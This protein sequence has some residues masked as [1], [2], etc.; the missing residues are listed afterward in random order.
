MPSV[1]LVNARD[2]PDTPAASGR[3]LRYPSPFFDLSQANLPDDI[4]ELFQWCLFYYVATPLIPAVVNKLS[5]Y[6][7]TDV[8]VQAKEEGEED[9]WRNFLISKL[10]IQF[11]LYEMNIDWCLYGNAIVGLYLPFKRFLGCKKCG[12]RQPMNGLDWRVKFKKKQGIEFKMKC[13][14]CKKIKP[15]EVYDVE[16]KDSSKVNIVRYNPNNIHIIYDIS[17]GK[18]KYLWRIPDKYKHVILSGNHPDIIEDCPYEVL[19]AINEEKDMILNDDNLFHMKRPNPSGAY[20]GFGLPLV[21]HALKWTYYFHILQSAQEAIAHDK[22]VPLDFIFPAPSGAGS[23]PPALSVG[24]DRFKREIEE[25][26][27]VQKKD[28]N[29]K[30]IVPFPIGTSRM[31]GDARAMML[32]PEI[33]WVS[34]QIISSMGVPVEFVYGGL[35]WTG[36]SITLRMLENS[37]TGMRDQAD[38][39]ISFVVGRVSKFMDWTKPEAYLTELKMADDIARQQLAMGLEASGKISTSS[40]LDELD[41]DFMAEEE[42]KAKEFPI[43]AKAMIREA[44]LNA[45]AQGEAGVLQNNYMMRTQ[46]QQQAQAATMG[47]DPAT[48]A[49][50]DQSGQP[51]DPNTGMPLDP[52]TGLPF[53]PNTG[54][55]YNPETGEVMT[56]EEAEEYVYSQQQGVA[57][58]QQA[59]GEAPAEGNVEGPGSAVDNAILSQEEQRDQAQE[60]AAQQAGSYQNAPIDLKKLITHWAQQL[61]GADQFTQRQYLDMIAED[62]PEVAELIEQEIQMIYAKNMQQGGASS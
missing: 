56:P 53:D 7:I 60:A 51:V 62:T 26:I 2:V 42:K 27:K 4:K 54:E 19:K 35:T 58:E 43:K 45:R 8:I 39:F 29:K 37:L 15:A 20:E 11:K 24:L 21:I 6:P 1:E 55:Y 16:I 10:N 52:N 44:M 46:I 61:A 31:G 47:M 5:Q 50:V 9:K 38:R 3:I 12:T 18:T 59:A 34:K 23:H 30:V 57:Q 40:L 33:E 49:P 32:G 48:G 22:I 14:T 13:P 36:S 41:W 25:G 28:P 17:S